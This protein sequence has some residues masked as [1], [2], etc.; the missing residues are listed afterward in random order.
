ME[1]AA[2]DSSSIALLEPAGS[3]DTRSA[4]DLERKVLELL[5]GGARQFAVDFSGVQ[6][7]TSAGLRVLIMLARRLQAV[8]GELV[9]CA[10]TDQVKTVFEIAGLAERFSIAATRAAAFERLAGGQKRA[11]GPPETSG[12]ARLATRLLGAATAARGPAPKRRA[13]PGG[14]SGLS[15]RVAALLDGRKSDH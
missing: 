9:L 6:L 3:I 12:L 4:L 15:D 8:E 2:G 1:T 5:S 7:I 13:K 10:L 11:A 14:G